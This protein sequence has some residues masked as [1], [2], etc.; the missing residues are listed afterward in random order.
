MNFSKELLEYTF[1]KGWKKIL[2]GW[3]VHLYAGRK[4]ICT[5]GPFDFK[6]KTLGAYVDGDLAA[7]VKRSGKVTTFKYKHIKHKKFTMVGPV[8]TFEET[9]KGAGMRFRS[10]N[11]NEGATLTLCDTEISFDNSRVFD[12]N[13]YKAEGERV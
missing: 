7:I 12:Y 3:E 11:L 13:P 6:P 2:K 9:P 1:N 4:R 8:T 5:F 10:V